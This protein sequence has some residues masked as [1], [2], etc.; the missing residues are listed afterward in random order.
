LR[1]VRFKL[2]RI[3][4]RKEESKWIDTIARIGSRYDFE[5]S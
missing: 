1:H 2:A 4:E 3:E 5:K